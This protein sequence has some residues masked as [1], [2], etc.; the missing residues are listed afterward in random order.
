[1]RDQCDGA[2]VAFFFKQWGEHLPGEF[3][4]S[5]NMSI[6]WQDGR[7][8]WYGDH[9]DIK[10][11]DSW[12]TNDADRLVISYRVG[13]KKAGRLLDGREHNEYPA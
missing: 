4:K 3:K 5:D 7:R 10:Y 13:K 12:L 1:V 2:G 6:V 8:E 9:A 11:S